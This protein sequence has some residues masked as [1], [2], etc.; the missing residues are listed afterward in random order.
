MTLRNLAIAAPGIQ[1]ALK[2]GTPNPRGGSR[3]DADG[4]FGLHSNQL[5]RRHLL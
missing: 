1:I 3:G 4:G 2:T 5:I